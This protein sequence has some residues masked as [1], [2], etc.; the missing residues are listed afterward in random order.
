[1][2]APSGCLVVMKSDVSLV[3]AMDACI[4]AFEI[5]GINENVLLLLKTSAGRIRMPASEP[6]AVRHA[7]LLS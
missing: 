5:F 4:C 2:Q 3:A 6:G 7:K 1:M